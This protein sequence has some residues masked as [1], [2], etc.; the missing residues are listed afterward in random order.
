MTAYEKLYKFNPCCPLFLRERTVE[1]AVAD[2]KKGS[3]FLWAYAHLYPNDTLQ[4][5][6]AKAL[7]AET[8]YDLMSAY[9][10]ALVKATLAY[11][12]GELGVHALAYYS[13]RLSGEL[14]HAD[15]AAR[16]CATAP[17]PFSTAIHAA[18]AH[19]MADWEHFDAVWE[20]QEALM[21]DI[22]RKVL[23]FD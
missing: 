2:C 3:W 6:K 13:S 18:R 22:C 9:G 5:A 16:A 11:A 17:Y 10:K 12:E 7:C 20:R 8:A 19:A 23:L 4:L 14:T 15:A 1:Q 21:A